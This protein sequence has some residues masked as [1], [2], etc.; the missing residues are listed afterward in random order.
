MQSVVVSAAKIGRPLSAVAGT[1]G[2][3]TRGRSENVI[4]HAPAL[5]LEKGGSMGCWRFEVSAALSL[6]V[7][8]VVALVPP[9]TGKIFFIH[10]CIIA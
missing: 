1:T 5:L 8:V 2:V 6:I 3:R 10:T 4:L 7:V 9:A